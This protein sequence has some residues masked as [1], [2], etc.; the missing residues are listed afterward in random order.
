MANQLYRPV[1]YQ[2]TSKENNIDQAGTG[3]ASAF[4]PWWGAMAGAGVEGTKKIRGNG[5]NTSRNVLA[6]Y[7]DPFNQFKGNKSGGDWA[8]SFLTPALGSFTKG[9]RV[10]RAA[11]AA[12]EVQRKEFAKITSAKS[13]AYY[14]SEMQRLA[15]DNSFSLSTIPQ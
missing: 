12:Q 1:P 2:Q 5:M 4:G 13:T 9:R 6:S 15:G 14:D 8:M 7:N 11:Q 3:I 10:K